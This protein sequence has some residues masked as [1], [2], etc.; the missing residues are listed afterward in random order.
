MRGSHDDCEDAESRRYSR[1]TLNRLRP[2]MAHEQ[3]AGSPLTLWQIPYGVANSQQLM[4]EE[5]TARSRS[6]SCFCRASITIFEDDSN[7]QSTS[8]H[9]CCSWIAATH[10]PGPTSTGRGRVWPNGSG[11]PRRYCMPVSKRVI[12]VTSLGRGHCSRPR[13]RVAESTTTRGPRWIGSSGL[14]Q[15]VVRTRRQ[16]LRAG[17][18]VRA[19][20]VAAQPRSP[21]PVVVLV[22]CRGCCWPC[23]LP[24]RRSA[25][26]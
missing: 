22:D 21:T 1:L 26:I 11:N 12:A 24:A 9:V 2:I 13:L 18:P 6:N 23:C 17:A 15:R 19:G 16:R 20:H 4:R 7:V 10:E 25:C 5:A 8:G 3:A 14:R